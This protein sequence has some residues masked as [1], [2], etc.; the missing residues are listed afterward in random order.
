MIYNDYTNR[1]DKSIEYSKVND[2]LHPVHDRFGIE[3]TMRL[4]I[5][6]FFLTRSQYQ[7]K[8]I[9]DASHMEK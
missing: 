1:S 2:S 3:L 7:S 9:S 6:C 5:F 8:F 4:D